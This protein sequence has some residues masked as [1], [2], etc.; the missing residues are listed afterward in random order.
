MVSGKDEVKGRRRVVGDNAISIMTYR[1]CTRAAP[2][3]ADASVRSR[4]QR[5]P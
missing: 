1:S 3:K 4:A 5:S 2:E